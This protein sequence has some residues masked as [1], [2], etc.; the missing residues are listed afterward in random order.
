[1]RNLPTELRRPL[2]WDRGGEI[3]AYIENTNGLLRQY[4]PKGS[5][6]SRYSQRQLNAIALRLNQH[7]RKTLGFQSPADKLTELP[8]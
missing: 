4:L 2:T 1:M 3:A 6:R 7:P 8:Q 5:D